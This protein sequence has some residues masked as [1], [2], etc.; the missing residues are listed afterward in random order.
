MPLQRHLAN[1]LSGR[2]EGPADIDHFALETHV[3]KIAEAIGDF[4]DK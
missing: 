3:A 1:S 4:L 2:L